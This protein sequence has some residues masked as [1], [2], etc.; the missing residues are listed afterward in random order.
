MTKSMTPQSPTG[1]E[2]L[3]LENLYYSTHTKLIHI[4]LTLQ[5]TK[6]IEPTGIGSK[7]YPT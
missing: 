5:R 2:Y 4:E 1:I 7:S 3:K 6:A